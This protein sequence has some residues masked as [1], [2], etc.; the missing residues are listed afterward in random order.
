VLGRTAALAIVGYQRFISPY[1]GFCCAYR[2]ETGRP[3]CSETARRIALRHGLLVLW[4]ALPRQFDRC[5]AAYA[6]FLARAASADE[7]KNK[8]RKWHDYCDIGPCDCVPLPKHCD[9][10][11]CG[12]MP[13]DCSL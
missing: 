7:D 4:K 1:K 2:W 8:E 6:A 11:D 9:V 5:R 10:G 12:V 3:S 13:C